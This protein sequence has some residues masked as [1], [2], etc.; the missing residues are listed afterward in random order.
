MKRQTPKA[1]KARAR[2]RKRPPRAKGLFDGDRQLLLFGG[3]E[4]VDP[5]KRLKEA[6][7]QQEPEA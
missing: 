6:R 7:K 2:G 1:N 4:Y 5:V 3:V